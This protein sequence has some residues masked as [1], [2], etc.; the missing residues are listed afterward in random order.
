MEVKS[1]SSRVGK[2]IIPML[3]AS[4]QKISTGA[5]TFVGK[6]D[7]ESGIYFQVHPLPITG[8]GEGR[9]GYSAHGDTS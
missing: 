7:W 9:N 3:T 6:L 8:T 4:P 1:K 5:C 2:S